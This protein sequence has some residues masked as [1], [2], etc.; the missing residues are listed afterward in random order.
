LEDEIQ[1]R[2]LIV[3]KIKKIAIKKIIIKIK[4]KNKSY[5]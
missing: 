2:I 3:K 4:I 1:K 5:I